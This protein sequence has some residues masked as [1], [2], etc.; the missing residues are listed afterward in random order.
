MERWEEQVS[1]GEQEELE[2]KEALGECWAL[3]WGPMSMNLPF[4]GLLSRLSSCV[5]TW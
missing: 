5:R 4:L 2:L 1:P 3:V